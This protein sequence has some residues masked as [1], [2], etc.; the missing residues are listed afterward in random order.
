MQRT[1]FPTLESSNQFITAKTE[2]IMPDERLETNNAHEQFPITNLWTN[3][4]GANKDTF[5]FLEID[6]LQTR[7]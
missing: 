5:Q 7:Q 1:R 4:F 3:C 6:Q 2:N